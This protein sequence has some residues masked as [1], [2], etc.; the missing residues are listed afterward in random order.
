[1][2]P[3]PAIDAVELWRFPLTMRQPFVTAAGAQ[4]DR[5]ILAVRVVSASG[6]GWGEC[7]AFAEPTYTAEFGDASHDV[8]RR[9]LAPMAL[10]GRADAWS[11]V[12][13]YPMA[14]A[15]L[16]LALLDL[17]L[18]QE[19][20]SLRE[21]LGGT[22]ELVDS[23]V[24]VGL[25]AS[26]DALVDE[27]MGYV[28]AGYRRVKLKIEPGHDVEPVRAVRQAVGPQ[29]ALQVDANGAYRDHQARLHA[30]DELDLL[31]IEQPLGDDDLVG[32]A[33]L[34]RTLRT[35]I[36]LDEAITSLDTAR[37]ALRLGACSIINVKPARVGG[38]RVA[39]AIH[40]LCVAEGVPLWC[41]GMLETGIGRAGALAVA[42]L[43]G[44]TLPADLSGSDRY[45]ETDI[46]DP[47]VMTDGQL[48]VPSGPGLGVQVHRERFGGRAHV[49]TIRAS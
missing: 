4:H 8:L 40:D 27:V 3:A 20:V 41:G 6:E 32:H 9:W 30:L 23:G 10:A 45:W 39:K 36:C 12:K 15:A 2:E 28:E 33:A 35:P 31:M 1:M 13:G 48:R 22:R 37:S 5:E 29:F 18:R 25:A 7:S 38:Y 26:I 19:Q 44:F 42:S 16:E 14:K 34:A 46:T 21:F 43:P 11:T 49:D 24:A 17:T 47:F